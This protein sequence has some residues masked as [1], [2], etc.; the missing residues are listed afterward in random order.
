MENWVPARV[1]RSRT[2]V[3]GFLDV[4][5]RTKEGFADGREMVTNVTEGGEINCG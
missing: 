5:G 4:V 1:V 2:E 3:E